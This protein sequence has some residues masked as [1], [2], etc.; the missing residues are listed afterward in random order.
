MAPRFSFYLKLL[1]AALACFAFVVSLSAQTSPPAPDPST[2]QPITGKQRLK[3]YVKGTVGPASLATG[4][5]SAGIGTANNNPNEY[6]PHWEGFG[7][8]YGIRLTGVATSNAIE[9]GLGALW[10]EDP[11]YFRTHD[12]TFKQ[13]IG[14]IMKMTF[15]APC[16]NGHLAP[17]YARLIAIP[18]SNFLSNSWRVDSAANSERAAIRTL[19]GFLGRM[20]GNAFKEFWPD[21]RQHVFRKKQ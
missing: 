16:P 10:G 18:G 2:Y 19:Y 4:I 7:K 15:V 3:W 14:N 20:G 8:R 9:G 13:R 12:A 5:F 17:A 6:G 11:R 21:I 1:Q